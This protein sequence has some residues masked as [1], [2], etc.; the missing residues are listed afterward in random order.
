MAD[1]K[2]AD[3]CSADRVATSDSAPESEACQRRRVTPFPLA[4]SSTVS[5]LPHYVRRMIDVS[6]DPRIDP[7]IKTVLGALGTPGGGGDA[8]SRE[9]L[10]AEA[11]TD[12]AIAQRAMITTLLGGRRQ[13]GDRAV[14]GPQRHRAL[15]R[16]AARRQHDQGAVHPARRTTRSLPVRVLHP[17]RRHADDVVLRRHLPRVGPHHRRPGRRRRDGR[18]PQRARRRRRSQEVA[19][20]PA[21][22]ND[23]VSG[24][25]WVIDHARRPRHRP[26]PHH[27]RRRERRR[28]PHARHR[29]QA[30]AGRRPRPDPGPLRAVP[31]H[32]RTLAAP[33]APV[34][35]RE[36]RHPPR[37]A[38]QPRRDGLRHRRARARQPA[39]VAELRDRGR[40][41]RPAARR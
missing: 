26:R 15:R 2:N 4:A 6:N 32:R 29:A 31:L 38:Q 22:L 20:F 36:Q 21:G 9:Q 34:V 19:P 13:R 41:A 37:P 17:R 35:D 27:R 7:R 5:R 14:E 8:E 18:L 1:G 25:Q 28:Q 3:K 39:G 16:V 10:L 33:G 30:E 12:E 11:N 23:C 40:R 24:L